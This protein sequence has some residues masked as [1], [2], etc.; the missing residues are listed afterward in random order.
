MAA[1]QLRAFLEHGN[2]RNAVNFPALTL[3]RAGG[4]R[5]AISNRNVPGM[6]GNI[7]SIF[8][9]ARLNVVDMLN[10]SRDNIAYNLI[11]VEGEPSAAVMAAIGAI[12]GVINVRLIAPPAC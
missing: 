5:V 7:L 6:L 11:D 10:K 2:I 1:D 8:A 4:W 9:E 3:E 12:E